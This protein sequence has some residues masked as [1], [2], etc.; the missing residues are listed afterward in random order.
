[1]NPQ[2]FPLFRALSVR[3]EGTDSEGVMQLLIDDEK[4]HARLCASDLE[5]WPQ[6]SN[7]VA[8]ASAI[9][10]RKAI[11]AVLNTHCNQS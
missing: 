6:L 10:A 5:A 8:R 2:E 4:L 1:M 7:A 3:L 9:R 11:D